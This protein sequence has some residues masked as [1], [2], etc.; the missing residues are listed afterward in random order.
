MLNPG[1]LYLEMGWLKNWLRSNEVTRVGPWSNR[2]SVFLRRNTRELF[3]SLFLSSHSAQRFYEH[4]ARWM[5]PLS[6]EKRS[7][8]EIYF[9]ST[10]IWDGPTSRTMRYK[11]LL[12]KLYRL[13]CWLNCKESTCQCRRWGFHLWVR[14]IPWRKKW[15]PTP[16]SLPGTSHGQR[17]LAGYNPWGHKRV[18]QDLVPK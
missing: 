7:Q 18:R 5:L 15:Q 14:K 1:W 9:A 4:T 12:C 11:F 16:G 10:L 3:F 17:S 6:Q 8:N 13:P 2:I